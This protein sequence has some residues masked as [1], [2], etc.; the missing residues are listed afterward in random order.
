MKEKEAMHYKKLKKQV[1]QCRL[2]PW[3]CVLKNDERG[4]CRVRLN[5]NGKLYTLVY[6]GPCSAAVDPVEKKPLFHFIPGSKIYSIG[7]PG[8]NLHCKFCQNW[9]ISQSN[10]EDV[11]MMHMSPKKVVENAIKAKCKAIAY[12]YT[13]PTIFYEYLYDTARIARRKGLKNIM[14]TNGFINSEPVKQ[15]CPY[16]DAVNV[17]LKGFS[18]NFYKDVARAKFKPV[19][20]TLKLIKKEGTFIEVTNLLI[21]KLNDDVRLVKKMCDWIVKNLGKDV[22]LHFSRFFPDYQLQHIPPTPENALF[23][24]REIALSFGL[25]FVYLGNIFV[26]EEDD[27][28]CPEC[29]Q[30]LIKRDAYTVVENNL[31]NG[32][33]R[34]GNE[35]P[36]IWN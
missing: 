15:L 1:V 19:L 9:I 22:P 10:P 26:D 12:T 14:V 27:T 24:A 20:D 35:I 6:A 2:C 4:K 33:C 13:E 32:F 3:S 5:R 25:N 36:G 29:K 11:E 7:T 17:D 8:C 23:K 28:L 18:E 34:C 30:V 16:I 21:P 31:K